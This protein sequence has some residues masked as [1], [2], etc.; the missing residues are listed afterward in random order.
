MAQD[1][2]S[3]IS[4]E[5]GPADLE[6]GV[7]RGGDASP[8]SPSKLH[9]IL[10]ASDTIRNS[11]SF[12]R[13]V[14]LIVSVALVAVIVAIP[15]TLPQYSLSLVNSAVL[16][17]VGAVALNLLTGWSGQIS[18]GSAA[19]LALGAWTLVV[20]PQLGFLLGT[21]VGGLVCAV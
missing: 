18:I 17:A 21:L 4:R 14:R 7:E 10:S 3:A 20:F 12:V 9:G 16:A 2:R 13:A 15:Q 6:H 19:F 5:V 11:A 1:D 8:L